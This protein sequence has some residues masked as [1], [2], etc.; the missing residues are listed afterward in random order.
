MK[1]SKLGRTSFV[2]LFF[3]MTLI[4]WSAQTADANS[5]VSVCDDAHLHTAVN[6]GGTVTFSCSGTIVLSTSSQ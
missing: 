1:C 4:L 3:A 2:I 5:V 6:A